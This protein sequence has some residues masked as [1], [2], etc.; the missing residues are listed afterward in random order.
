MK[1]FCVRMSHRKR[2]DQ[3]HETGTGVEKMNEWKELDI[4][5]LP[6]DILVGD[7]EWEFK[8]DGEWKYARASCEQRLRGYAIDEMISQNRSPD[9]IEKE[10]FPKTDPIK[11]RYRLRQSEPPSH[12]EIMTKW[13]EVAHC[14]WYKV[15]CYCGYYSIAGKDVKKDWFT[16]RKSA[17]IPP[18]AK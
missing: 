2:S 1:T 5:N 12:E 17:T 3:I 8:T 13:W 16:G 9:Q 4:N 6:S 18:G 11:Y 10:G 7:Y 15:T 14:E